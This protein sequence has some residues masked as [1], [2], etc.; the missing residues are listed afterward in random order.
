MSRLLRVAKVAEILDVSESTVR[1]MV[2]SGELP[3]RMI[4]GV[5]RIPVAAI[6]QLA[7]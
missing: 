4:R 7:E 5:L 2:R 3:H 6:E 1:R